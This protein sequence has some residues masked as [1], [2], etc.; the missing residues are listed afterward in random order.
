[1]DIVQSFFFDSI[2]FGVLGAKLANI[3]NFISC[4]RDLGFWYD[5][6]IVKRLRFFNRFATKLL[7]NSDAVKRYAMNRENVSEDSIKVI[8]N[9]IDLKLF[10]ETIAADLSK[11]FKEIAQDD[12]VVGM[13]ANFN[14]KVKRVDLFI[15]AAAELCKDV[16]S[17][18]FLIIGGG[19]LERSLRQLV[20]DL[21]LGK[22][23]IFAGKRH[24]ATPYIKGFDI[25]VVSSDSEGFSNA[26]L[27][28]M[29]AGIAVVATDAGG[30]GELI[31]N[32]YTGIL[33]PIG[34]HKAIAR[35]I[36]ALLSDKERRMR[37]G[38]EARRLVEKKYSWDVKIR[39]IES[40]YYNLCKNSC[41]KLSG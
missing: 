36:S 6:K 19:K 20:S 17:I 16:A 31:E 40:Y 28:Y 3:R 27:E 34:D 39:E 15:S 18:K 12:V 25:G 26:A 7:V 8:H 24:D 35:E 14:R 13:V 37:M 41:E 23:I 10:D 4:R 21:G 1:V 29:A 2:L 38:Q 5:D 22:E 32:G 9:G 11:E 30:N 33:T